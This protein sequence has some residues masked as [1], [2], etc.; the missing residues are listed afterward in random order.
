MYVVLAGTYDKSSELKFSHILSL[1]PSLW[2]DCLH[3][4]KNYIQL[5]WDTPHAILIFKNSI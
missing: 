4:T 3:R 1:C 2:S 5:M